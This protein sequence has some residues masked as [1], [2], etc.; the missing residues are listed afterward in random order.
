VPPLE[1][2]ERTLYVRESAEPPHVAVHADDHAPH[3]PSQL[4]GHAWVLHS[5]RSTAPALAT[6]AVPP[7]AAAVVTANVRGIAAP[8]QVAVHNDAQAPHAPTQFTGHPCVLHASDSVAPLVA[9]QPAPPLEAAVVMVNVRGMLE[10]PQVAVHDDAHAPHE[11]TQFTGQACVLHASDSVAPL[12]DE[13]AVPPLEAAVVMVNVRGMLEPPQ[14]A[15]HVDAQEPHAPTQLTGQACVLHACD[16]VAPLV[17]EQAVP[18]LEAAVVMVNVRRM[19]EPPHVAV[20]VDAHAPHAPT[21]FTALPAAAVVVLAQNSQG[22][23]TSTT[24]SA[25]KEAGQ[26]PP[27]QLKRSQL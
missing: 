4:P 24:S 6:Q 27:S 7:F 22:S 10:P 15:V 16:S 14:V 2:G 8:P 13:Q 25:Q 5:W 11:P 23:V 21:Q 9:A 3:E 26:S 17:Y 19:F 1:A 18:P 20:Q 12:A